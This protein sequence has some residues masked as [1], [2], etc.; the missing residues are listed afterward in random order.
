VIVFRVARARECRFARSGKTD[1][2]DALGPGCRHNG[3]WY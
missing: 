1:E 2:N 3:R